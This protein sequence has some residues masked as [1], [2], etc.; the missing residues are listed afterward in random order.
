MEGIKSLLESGKIKEALTQF[1]IL[2]E[3]EQEDFFRAISPTL[4]P[5]SVMAVLYRKLKPGFTFDDFYN[6]WLPPLGKDESLAHHFSAPTYVMNAQNKDD[7]NEIISI[8][9]M[10][11]TPEA[12]DNLEQSVSESEKK[13]HDSIEKVAHKTQPTAIYTFKSITKLG[14]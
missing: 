3:T 5:P 12:F 6:A 10:W 13:R 11:I 14:S 2:S 7:P 1:K 9:F 8:S 4:F